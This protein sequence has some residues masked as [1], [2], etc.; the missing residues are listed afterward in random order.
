[1]QVE[2]S[3]GDRHL[4]V[5][6]IPFNNFSGSRIGILEVASDV[7][8]IV[9][10][11]HNAMMRIIVGSAVIALLSLLGF[12]V[13]EAV[14]GMLSSDGIEGSYLSETKTC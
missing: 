10:H 2:I 11:S 13:F 8:T 6:A 3:V 5:K 4:V 9:D 7:T 14:I 1:M 12:F